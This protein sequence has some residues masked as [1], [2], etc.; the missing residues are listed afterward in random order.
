MNAV[1]KATAVTE[2]QQ[3]SV[4]DLTALTQQ[5]AKTIEQLQAQL[6]WFKKQLF[7]EKSEKRVVLPEGIHQSSLFDPSSAPDSPEDQRPDQQISYSRKKGKRIVRIA[8]PIADSAL[9]KPYR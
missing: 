6:E 4:A 8:L 2:G 1:A 7:G 9:M 5:Q 3:Q